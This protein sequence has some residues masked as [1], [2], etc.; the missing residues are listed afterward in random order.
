MLASILIV[1]DHNLTRQGIRS[2]V[3][4]ELGARVVADTGDGLEVLP[5]VNEHN[6]DLLILDL[7]LPHQNGLDILRTLQEQSSAV[8]VVVLS[9]HGDDA[10]VTKAFAL[11]ASAYVLKGAPSSELV[12]ALRAA[13][14]GERYLSRS[15]PEELMASELPASDAPDDRY[16][17]LTAR[18]REILRLTAEGL[19]SPEMA[20]RLDISSRTVDKHR[21]HVKEKLG[22]RN[23][24]E[25]AAYA[26]RRGLIPEPP[27]LDET[28]TSE[29]ESDAP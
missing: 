11:G 6:P 28:P 13:N 4:D 23:V 5:L 26:H 16:E 1:E 9:M 21:Q 22:L 12:E 3:E 18:E 24:A 25:M 27:P 10:Y 20:D 14:R 7:G 15:L 19:T 17:L 2:M 29:T 8:R